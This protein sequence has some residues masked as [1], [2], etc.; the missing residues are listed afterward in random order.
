ML[1]PLP[2]GTVYRAFGRHPSM[3][4]IA[5]NK[6]EEADEQEG[7]IMAAYELYPLYY[8][9]NAKLARFHSSRQ[10]K[11]RSAFVIQL[12]DQNGDIHDTST[13]E[14]FCSGNG[15]AGLAGDCLGAA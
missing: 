7:A 5:T 2:Q 12:T 11:K 1:R 9:H 3:P 6:F 14:Y 8:R 15:L 13:P 4:S 10:K